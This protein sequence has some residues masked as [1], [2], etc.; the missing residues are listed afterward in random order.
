MRTVRQR[1]ATIGFLSPAVALITVF[2]LVP[3]AL[4]VWLSLHDWSTATPFSDAT[5]NGID[6]YKTLFGED[7]RPEPHIERAY[8]TARAH[9]WYMTARLIT[10]NDLY[11]FDPD[12]TVE[13]EE[14][15][16]IVGRN[17]KQPK[18]GLGFDA[19]PSAHMWRT[20]NWPTRYL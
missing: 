5:W 1:V 10:V 6:N 17:F 20:I 8:Q 15:T 9:K 2:I 19:S 4:T 18:E 16:D 7:Y 11:S 12:V 14:F 13:L 3:I